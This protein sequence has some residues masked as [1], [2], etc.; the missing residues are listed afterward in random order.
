MISLEKDEKTEKWREEKKQKMVAGEYGMR[1]GDTE[2][3]FDGHRLFEDPDP[4][5]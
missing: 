1:R 5:R 4:A 2:F 3:N